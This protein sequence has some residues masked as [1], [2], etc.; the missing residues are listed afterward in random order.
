MKYAVYCLVTWMWLIK[1]NNASCQVTG[2]VKSEESIHINWYQLCRYIR[3]SIEYRVQCPWLSFSIFFCLFHNHSEFWA[4]FKKWHNLCQ[5][6]QKNCCREWQRINVPR[7]WIEW[8]VRALPTPLLQPIHKIPN[9]KKCGA[10]DWWEI[11][12]LDSISRCL[13]L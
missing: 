8:M 3:Y 1:K 4:V 13:W 12:R 2:G 10:S 5:N 9:K 11:W 6:A 7:T